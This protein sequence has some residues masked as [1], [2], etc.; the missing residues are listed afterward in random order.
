M[1]VLSGY[2]REV[3]MA[4]VHVEKFLNL[5]QKATLNWSIPHVRVIFTSDVYKVQMSG[6]NA[7]VVLDGEN[8]M[9]EGI[10][11]TDEWEMNFQDCVKNVKA[12]LSI[13]LPDEHGFADITMKDEKIIVKSGNQKTQCFFCSE[14]IPAVSTKREPRTMGDVVVDFDID[15]EFVTAYSLVKKVAGGFGKVYF[16]VEEGHLFIEAGD[17]TS[18]HTNNM[19][20]K[21]QEV[22]FD[23]I[24]VCFDF[25]SLNDIMVLMNGDAYDTRFTLGYQPQ[26][27]SG[28]VAFKHNDENFY[29]MSLRENI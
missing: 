19:L 17:R 20:I 6:S 11:G 18:P 24:F 23:D 14:N 22:E 10:A 21:L 25:K 5:L 9:I 12:Y 7:L 16:G 13:I 29:L 4:R 26:R 1:C 15:A 27:R 3:I 28:L 2:Y 8:D